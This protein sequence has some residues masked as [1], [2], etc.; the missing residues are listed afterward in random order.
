MSGDFSFIANTTTVTVHDYL[1]GLKSPAQQE[2]TEAAHHLIE[3]LIPRVQADIKWKIPFY[4]YLKPLC[5]LNPRKQGGLELCF[6]QGQ[7]LSD[8]HGLLRADGRKMIKGIYIANLEEL[9]REEVAE[10]ILE[11]AVVNEMQ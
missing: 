9:Y 10:T 7:M 11:A 6:M 5:Y 4:T 2:L 1:A 3:S 8:A